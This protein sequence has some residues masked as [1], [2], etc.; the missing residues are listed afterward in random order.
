MSFFDSIGEWVENALNEWAD[1]ACSRCGVSHASVNAFVAEASTA[2]HD[3][4]DDWIDATVDDPAAEA[5]K[6]L[7]ESTSTKGRRRSR[8]TSAPS[9]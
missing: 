7:V 1:D 4:E 9:R 8:T 6:I 3:L 2:V 5:L